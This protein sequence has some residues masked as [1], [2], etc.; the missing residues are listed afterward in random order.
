M[1]STERFFA[2]CRGRGGGGV[3][4]GV[5][6]SSALMRSGSNAALVTG[7]AR[8]SG[9]ELRAMRAGLTTG[10][11]GGFATGRGGS[12]AGLAAGAG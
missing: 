5:L 2:S 8:G 10:R 6:S 1:S 7:R 4:R 12:G 11:G 9:A 3:W